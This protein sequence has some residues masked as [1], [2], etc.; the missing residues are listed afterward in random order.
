MEVVEER[1]SLMVKPNIINK[2]LLI[3]SSVTLVISIFMVLYG[4]LNMSDSVMNG[5][6]LLFLASFLF[7]LWFFYTENRT[8]RIME[9]PFLEYEQGYEMAAENAATNNKMFFKKAGLPYIFLFVFLIIINFAIFFFVFVT[10]DFAVTDDFALVLIVFMV[11]SLMI[12]VLSI[13]SM[14][15][16]A[17][18]GLVSITSKGVYLNGKFVYF[19]TFGRSLQSVRYISG[20]DEKPGVM[21]ITYKD[22]NPKNRVSYTFE[23]HVFIPSQYN[24]T[25]KEAASAIIKEYGCYS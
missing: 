17:Q 10:G 23:T 5:G 20:N 8:K 18:E 9:S 13:Y 19:P 7:L 12:I 14:R 3:G 6:V 22:T 21:K 15:F 16:K 24:Q 25:A 1:G 11:L 4:Y 2:G